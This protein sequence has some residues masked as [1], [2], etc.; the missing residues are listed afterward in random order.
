MTQVYKLTSPS[1]KHYIGLTSATLEERWKQHVT[2]WKKLNSKGID[3]RGKQVTSILFYAF[4]KYHP[5][6]WLKE[7]VFETTN[8]DEAKS[9]EIELI[10]QLNTTNSDFGYNV[11]VGGQTGWAGKNLSEEHK[12]KQAKTRSEWYK[13]EEGKIWKQQ[14]SERWANTENN[15]STLKIGQPGTKHSE[16]TKTKI[17]KIKKEYYETHD[18]PNKGKILSDDV[19]EKMS[20]AK[21]GKKLSP[22]HREKVVSALYGRKQT[23]NQKKIATET[24]SMNWEITTPDGEILIIRNLRQFCK[25]NKLSQGNLITYGHTKGYRVKKLED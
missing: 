2:L 7:I 25:D 4:D 23:F 14:L 22:E 20:L 19:K 3:Y 15:P 17:S 9:K 21:K 1:G 16:E 5:D 10:E 12:E 6:T 18:S 8:L 11:L 24:N 13:T